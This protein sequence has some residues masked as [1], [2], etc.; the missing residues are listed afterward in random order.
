MMN[1]LIGGFMTILIGATLLNDICSNI[2]SNTN[3]I[4]TN[5]LCYLVPDNNS[6]NTKNKRQSYLEYVEER[7]EVERRMR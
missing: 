6:I 5:T 1:N 4:N 3:K 7:L 2:N